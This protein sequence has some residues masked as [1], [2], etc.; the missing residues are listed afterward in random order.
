MRCWRS[1]VCTI[2]PGPLHF[3]ADLRDVDAVRQLL[4]SKADPDEKT[5]SSK[6][7][8][9][10]I[11][12]EDD[13]N[14]CWLAASAE[15]QILLNSA[16]TNPRTIGKGESNSEAKVEQDSED[17]ATADFDDGDD[18]DDA[19]EDF[20]NDDDDDDATEDFEG[21]GNASDDDDESTEDMQ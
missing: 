8:A 9:L 6:L 18:D 19:T 2:S 7:S 10:D 13:E 14:K 20:D 11:A 1:N 3:A 16:S 5:E 21:G 15:I 12:F 4:A 17:D